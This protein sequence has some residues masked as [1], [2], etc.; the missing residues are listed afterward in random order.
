MS[1][2]ELK[3]NLHRMVV[4]TEDPEILAQIAT[5]F[6]SLLGG[7]DGGES[8]S[9]EEKESIEQGEAA[10]KAGRPIRYFEIRERARDILGSL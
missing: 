4:E 3:N 5:R 7:K 6:A 2:A 1:V 10:P 8:M 9:N